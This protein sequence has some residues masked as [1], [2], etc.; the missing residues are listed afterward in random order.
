MN[1]GTEITKNATCQEN[2]TAKAVTISGVNVAPINCDEPCT[3]PAL[4]PRRFGVDSFAIVA[5]AI[6]RTGPSEIPIRARANTKVA[7][8]L[9]RPE[10]MVQNENT[11]AAGTKTFLLEPIKS[12][13]ELNI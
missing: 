8:F 2:F 7:K 3:I 4:S 10:T 12:D 11:K 13:T 1:P 9:A 5:C 6:G